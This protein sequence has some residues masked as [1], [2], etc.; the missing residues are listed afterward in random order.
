MGIAAFV[1]SLIYRTFRLTTDEEVDN[2]PEDTRVAKLTDEE[3]RRRSTRPDRLPIASPATPT[4]PTSWTRCRGWR[5]RDDASTWPAVLTPLPVL[6]PLIASAATLVAG[7]RP[8]LQRTIT[9]IALSAVVAVCAALL[10]LADRDGTIALQVGGWGQA[11]PEWVRW[12][13]PWW[14]T[15]F[16]R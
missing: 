7:R 13:S 12:A 2:D 9:L 8:R 1:L 16:R 6:I 14:W 15:G 10:Y 4:N 3:T 5:G 11:W